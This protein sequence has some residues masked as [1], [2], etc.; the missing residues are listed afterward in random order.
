MSVYQ[1]ASIRISYLVNFE[2]RAKMFDNIKNI[3]AIWNCPN[4][5]LI[6]WEGY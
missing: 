3:N 4:I 1:G 5:Y 2:E 6:H